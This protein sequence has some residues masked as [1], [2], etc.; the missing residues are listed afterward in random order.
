MMQLWDC[1]IFPAFLVT[2]IKQSEKQS[3]SEAIVIIWYGVGGSAPKL[4][5]QVRREVRNVPKLASILCF[6]TRF[7]ASNDTYGG[8]LRKRCHPGRPALIDPV[9]VIPS[10][11]VGAH[12][13]SMICY[14]HSLFLRFFF[15]QGNVFVMHRSYLRPRYTVRKSE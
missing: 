15:A 10:S 1:F 4:M 2:I 8:R 12:P 5:Y 11:W 14:M 6:W 9:V 3:L 13:R 7:W